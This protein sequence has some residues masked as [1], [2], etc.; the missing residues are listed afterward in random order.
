MQT[1]LLKGEK[2]MVNTCCFTWRGTGPAAEAGK[3]NFTQRSCKQLSWGPTRKP[4]SDRQ[5]KCQL[6]RGRDR[7]RGQG[8]KLQVKVYAFRSE[9][10][11]AWTYR[12]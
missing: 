12:K 7:K 9:L 11:V 5:I 6:G 3:G 10:G 1:L 2:P 8:G 4:A